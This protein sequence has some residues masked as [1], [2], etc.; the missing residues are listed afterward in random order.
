M[1]VLACVLFVGHLL[2][3]R[4]SLFF[5]ANGVK[6]TGIQF[7]KKFRIDQESP[8]YGVGL[9]PKLSPALPD[10]KCQARGLGKSCHT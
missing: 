8:K 5:L 2:H 9:E 1:I 10:G 7:S 4:L 6:P 3:V